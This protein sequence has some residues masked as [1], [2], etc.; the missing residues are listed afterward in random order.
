MAVELR[1]KAGPDAG[2]IDWLAAR[3]VE[4]SC[5]STFAAGSHRFPVHVD[6]QS[7]ERAAGV[8][9]ADL[10]RDDGQPVWAR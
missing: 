4:S 8:C 10:A 7:W 5:A 1:T 2:L 9:W 3:R 6:R